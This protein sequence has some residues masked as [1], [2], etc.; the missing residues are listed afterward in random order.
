MALIWK[1]GYFWPTFHI[2]SHQGNCEFIMYGFFL[3]WLLV[4]I[5]FRA[6]LTQSINNK[7]GEQN[8][9]WNVYTTDIYLH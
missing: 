2:F 8:L 3:V 6:I 9:C 7:N 4:L 5:L 1:K